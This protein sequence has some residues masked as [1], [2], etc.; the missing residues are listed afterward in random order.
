[1][2]GIWADSDVGWRPMRPTPFGLE[3][4]LHDLIESTPTM[5]PLAGRPR[6]ALLG[7]EVACGTGYADLVGVELDTGRPV[8]IEVKL[9]SNTDRRQ[10]LTQVLGYAAAIRGMDRAAFERLFP[11]VIGDAAEAAAQ[12]PAFD[13]VVF[14]AALHESLTNGHL[15]CVIVLDRAPDELVDLVG[16]LQ[17][18]TND[19]LIIDLIT[20]AGYAVG[21]QRIMVPQLVEPDGPTTPARVTQRAA[22]PTSGSEQFAASIEHAPEPERAEL[23][24]LLEWARQLER[25]GLATL[26]TSQGR[27]RWVLNPRLPG[28]E[29]GMVTI[30]NE[31]GAYLSPY[32]TV[33]RAE[34]PDALDELDH[35]APDVIGQ[36]NSI[37][38]PFPDS[39]L[40]GLRTAYRR[41]ATRTVSPADRQTSAPGSPPPR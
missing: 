31:N 21:D 32:R 34:A 27:G 36:G 18:V 9:A 33:L 26:Y 7:R 10:V 22:V 30:W 4:E 24:R 6:L 16:Y 11:Q 37:R 15:R 5:L 3:K 19:R 29:R 17:D 25:D 41:A 13:P 12:D 20:V 23:R 2:T 1:M 39:L 38:P 28:Q 40:D 14:S 35:T 8:V